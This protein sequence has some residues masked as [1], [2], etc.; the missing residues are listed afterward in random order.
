VAHVL[1]GTTLAELGREVHPHG[2][3]LPLDPPGETRT[4]GGVLA[5]AALGPR[6]LGF[7]A[8]R[9]CVLGLEVAL[10][11]GVRTRCGG[12]VVKNVTGY[13]LAKLY[14]GSFG[15]L[16][17]IEAAW[18]R[19]HP[20][21][22][23]VVERAAAVEAGAE[24]LDLGL[25]AARRPSAR[26]AALLTSRLARQL[27]P[28]LESGSRWL[29]VCEFAGD[30]DTSRDDAVWLDRRATALGARH[31][32]AQESPKAEGLTARLRRLQ[33]DCA[34]PQGLRARIAVLPSAL[35]RSCAPLLEAGAELLIYPGL[36][37]V[38]GAFEPDAD[39]AE[40]GS[41]PLDA[42]LAAVG[43]AVECGD[44]SWVLEQL[45]VWAK[46]GREVFGAPSAALSLMRALKERFDPLGVL[47]RGRFSGGI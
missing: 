20:L 24:A 35:E 23:C 36:G 16:G 13:D 15:T 9:D 19:L 31:D 17:V 30:A 10:A 26:A 43:R 40:P 33:G 2:W 28:E 11:S 12:R 39:P 37:L 6:R 3:E 38:Y 44:G 14:T 4:L 1:A 34:A 22:E 42:A 46:A 25:A 21:P 18:V 41:G 47:N 8:A 45:P 7:G 29:L 32:D 27:A 5:S